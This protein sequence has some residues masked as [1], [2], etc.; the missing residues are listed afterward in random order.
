MAWCPAASSYYMNQCWLIIKSFLRH[1]YRSNFIKRALELNPLRVFRDYFF[2]II[3]TSLRGKLVNA[4]R[5]RVWITYRLH[6]FSDI[7]N[8]YTKGRF[9]D[10]SIGQHKQLSKLILVY[11]QLG[12]KIDIPLN[13]YFIIQS[14][15]SI[16]SLEIF[17]LIIGIHSVWISRNANGILLMKAGVPRQ[18]SHP[19]PVPPTSFIDGI[20]YSRSHPSLF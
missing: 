6:P 11:C 3:T 7:C 4:L 5:L 8:L 13:S 10:Q 19:G 16:K 15:N 9:P 20:Q 2:K 1:S 14:F 12:P 17:G 18:V